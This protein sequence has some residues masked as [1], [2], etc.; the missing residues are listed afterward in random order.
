MVEQSLA[1][2][3]FRNDVQKPDAKRNIKAPCA[4]GMMSAG[5]EVPSRE[6]TGF[7]LAVASTLSGHPPPRTRR[8][9]Y[10]GGSGWRVIDLSIACDGRKRRSGLG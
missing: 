4:R 2:G 7:L 5:T 3:N 10:D 8:L 1:T 9:I 6:T